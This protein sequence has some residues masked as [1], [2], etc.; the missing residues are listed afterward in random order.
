MSQENV[1][2]VRRAYATWEHGD[3][4]P[5]EYWAEDLEWWASSN[6]P[7]TE[8][9]R[10]RS[11]V[12]DV[13]HDWLDHLGAY[14]AKFEFIDAGDDE[15]VVC[16]SVLLEGAKIPVLAYQACRVHMGK[17]DRVRAYSQLHDALTAV[18]LT[19]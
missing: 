2:I 13:L 5:P 8:A 11:A 9:T 7:D 6:D 1:E 4:V 19:E 3:Y 15:V 16:M 12:H 18:G 14:E 10:G 17:I